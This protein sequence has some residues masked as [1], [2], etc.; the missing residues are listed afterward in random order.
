MG[1]KTIKARKLWN[2][3]VESQVETGTPYMVYKDACNR[4][5]NQQN[6]GTIRC[7][8]LCTEIVEYT[9]PDEVAV[10]NLASLALP[11]FLKEGK[12]DFEKLIEVMRVVVRNLNR[13]IDYN[14]YPVKEAENSN[15][16]HRPMG[17]GVQGFA[18]LLAILKLDFD[19][20]EA[21]DLNSQI[22]ETM[23]YAAVRESVE[24]AKI[25]GPYQSFKGSPASKG[26]L[27]FDMWGVKPK[28]YDWDPVK[29]DVMKF[30]MRN[31]LLLAP[32]P[33]ASTSQILG[34][35]ET[36]EP[37]TANVYARR[38]LSGEFIC[39][40]KHLVRDLI[41]L[42]LWDRDLR[43]QI[44]ANSGSIQNIKK[45]PEKF[46]KLYRTVWELP[47]KALIN[48]AV[49]RGPFIDQSQSL[50]IF[51]ESPQVNKISSMHFYG[52]KK[53][54][55]TGMYYLRSRPAVDAIKFTV[56]YEKLKTGNEEVLKE[57]TDDGNVL[58][59][60]GDNGEVKENKGI[61]RV[62]KKLP[63][64]TLDQFNDEDMCLNCG[65]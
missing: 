61:K 6:L 50:N 13:V 19:S 4:K 32:M 56:D 24:L 51:M 34:N 41:K 59:K 35:N 45:I 55:K 16:K 47:Q 10:C 53:G 17:I 42:G 29:K 22:F 62:K 54:L 58:G 28:M 27:Q 30:G 12:F 31:S 14:Y 38:V 26:V 15:L 64:M 36:F 5:S 9:S 2:E 1:R 7:S 65:S 40:N 60:R 18:D 48:L 21:L 23:Y 49:G 11:K 33:T 57:K 25:E 44:L 63:R 37:F 43:Q 46:R 20:Q 39:I 52:W 3:I 8:N